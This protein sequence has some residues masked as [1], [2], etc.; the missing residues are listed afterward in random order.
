MVRIFDGLSKFGLFAILTIFVFAATSTISPGNAQKAAVPAKSSATTAAPKSGPVTPDALVSRL[1]DEEVRRM[2]L[3]RLETSSPQ[4][5]SGRE[6][7]NPAVIIYRLQRD[8][9]TLSAE[10]D[11]IFSSVVELPE[12][13]PRAWRQFTADRKDGGVVWFFFAL[14]ISMGFGYLAERAVRTGLLQRQ[15]SAFGDKRPD[16]TR[17]RAAQ[18]G[19]MLVTRVALLMVFIAVA[20]TVFLLFFDDGTKDR[21]TFFFYLTAT[22][23]FRLSGALSQTF[24]APRFPSLR[25]PKY[26]DEDAASL[27]AT[28]LITVGFGA[29]A[30]FT[31]ALFGTLGVNGEVHELFLILVGTGTT[32]LLVWSIAKG[33]A[34]ISS[35]IAAGAL[36]GTARR[37]FADLWPWIF[38]GI[39]IVMWIGLVVTE[40]LRDFVPYGAALFTIGVMAVVPSIDALLVRDTQRLQDAG[41]DVLS[42]VAR[43]ARLA[44]LAVVVVALSSAWRINPM[45]MAEA[46]IGGQFA[47]A[48]LQVTLTLLVAYV[49]WQSLQI[50]IDRKIAEEDAEMAASGVDPGEMEIGGT[51]LSRMRTLL[52][53]CRKTVQITLFVIVTMIV[54][55]SLGVDIAP[56]LAGAGVVGLAIGFGSQ[57]LVRDIVSGAFFLI[58]DAFRLGEYIDVGDVKGTVEKMSVRSL[59]LRHHRGAVHTVPF[60]EIKTLTNYSRDW[61]IMKLKF[62]VPFDTD[63]RKVK[64]IFKQIGQ[65]LLEHPELADDFI[66][67][68]K[69][70][71]VMEV[72]DYGLV[73]R[74][75]F[76]SKPGRQFMIR[77]EAY[78]LVQAAFEEHG[79]DFAKPEVRVVVGDDDDDRNENDSEKSVATV[80]AAGAAA[81]I[82]TAPRP[83]EQ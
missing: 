77:K 17:G 57:T 63:V 25:L 53:L 5:A 11:A 64:R 82:A 66:Q 24:H 54:L 32:G 10:L 12:I 43:G 80:A 44:L 27:H 56:I 81:R 83:V 26:S 2:L 7:F 40:L 51:G 55:A 34:A 28:A 47:G 49:I 74:A 36:E 29:F 67:P 73:L 58:D 14:A 35:D 21:I 6:E 18:L 50:Y 13:F 39:S 79:I 20:T 65:E 23:I 9:G 33:R 69:S 61:A 16:G 72:D 76:M 68:F 48:M 62:R 4:G 15:I 59:R 8:L 31:C 60:G 30:F 52:P 78:I 37:T 70:Q 75:K 3:E 41:D 45:Q 38:A 42:A 22:G 19:A 1:S 71:G 46:G